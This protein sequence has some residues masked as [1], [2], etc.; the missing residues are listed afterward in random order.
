MSL[1]T[2]DNNTA[3]EV[4]QHL[5]NSSAT[6]LIHSACAELNANA[7]SNMPHEN[8]VQTQNFCFPVDY[9][10]IFMHLMILAVV[11]K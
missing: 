2:T 3:I 8:S 5:M 6:D 9:F 1:L 11:F 7:S 10:F 4:H